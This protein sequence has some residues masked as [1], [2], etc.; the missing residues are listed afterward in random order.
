MEVLEFYFQICSI[1]LTSEALSV[2]A[3]TLANGGLNPLTRKR[4]FKPETVRDCLSIM[5]S[6][7]MYDYSG[8][9]QF[10]IGF[11]VSSIR[12]ER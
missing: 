6:S 10:S 12:V 4:V 2:V 5:S 7:G 8:E 3:A 9:F 11:P 1:Q